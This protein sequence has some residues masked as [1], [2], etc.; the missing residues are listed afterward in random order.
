[1]TNNEYEGKSDESFREAAKSAVHDAE[2]DFERRGEEPPTD[3]EISLRAKAKKGS[4][5]SEYVVIAT[6]RD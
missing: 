3:Y 4:S 5:L 6:P 1:M 2:R